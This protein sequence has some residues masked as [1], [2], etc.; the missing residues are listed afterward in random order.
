MQTSNQKP[1]AGRVALVT[2][3]SRRNGI[4]FAIA[5]RLAELGADL[6]I[7]AY[8]P[9]DA[10]QSWGSDPPGTAALLTDLGQSG[11]RVEHLELDFMAA[12]APQT[13]MN[14]AVQAYQHVDILVANHAY[15]TMGALEEVTAS[16]IDRHLQVNVRATLLLV[17]AFAAQHDDRPGGRVVFMTS[18]QH[19]SPMV[20]EL[21]YIA[22]KGA[23]HPLGLS[24]AAYLAPRGIT[25]NLVNPGATDTGYASPALYEAVLAMEPQGRWGQ[26]T[27]AARLIG[28]LCTDDAHWITGQVINSTG[29]GP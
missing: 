13:L 7:H 20:G 10:A 8:R 24:L 23:L 28:W 25:V 2:G 16:E 15:S 21:A 17:K 12:D 19:R 6:F 29:G 3:C 26:P 22:S 5:T 27:D 9:F 14:A 11:R 4:G 18:G 1:L